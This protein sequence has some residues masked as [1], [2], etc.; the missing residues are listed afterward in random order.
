MTDVFCFM[1]RNVHC[2][3]DRNYENAVC[4][5]QWMCDECQG[6]QIRYTWFTEMEVKLIPAFEKRCSPQEKRCGPLLQEKARKEGKSRKMS[7][8]S[9]DSAGGT[10]IISSFSVVAFIHCCCCCGFFSSSSP[11]FSSRL[12]WYF[13]AAVD[14]PVFESLDVECCCGCVSV[15]ESGSPLTVSQFGLVFL[16][17]LFI[18]PNPR[19]REERERA[20]SSSPISFT[21][22]NLPSR[23]DSVLFSSTSWLTRDWH[24]RGQL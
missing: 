9:V 23:R 4:H 8:K 24:P 18:H 5:K 7:L 2:T 11:G 12:V 13:V 16:D 15:N 6:R 22:S 17:S 21:S 3:H 10:T 1:G 14:G 19:R 20:S